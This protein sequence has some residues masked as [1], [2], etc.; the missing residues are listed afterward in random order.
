MELLIGDGILY[1]G[2]DR[3]D[4]SVGY[5]IGNIVPACKICNFAK[6]NLTQDDFKSWAKRIS[7]MAEQWSN[8]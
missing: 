3:V 2:I 7:A 4:S 5:E 8:Q 1:S 6:S